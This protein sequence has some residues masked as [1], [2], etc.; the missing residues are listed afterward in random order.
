MASLFAIAILLDR[1]GVSV[2]MLGVA[3]IVVMIVAPQVVL[4]PSF[5][6]SFAAVTLLIFVGGVYHDGVW[7][8][9]HG[10]SQTIC[11]A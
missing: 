8:V 10:K 11:L 7:W 6:M 1:H 5:Q 2:R 4:G 3:A 9:W